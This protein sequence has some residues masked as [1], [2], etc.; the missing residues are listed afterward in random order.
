MTAE[1][2][3]AAD[4]LTKGWFVAAED[5]WNA[6][7]ILSLASVAKGVTAADK[8]AWQKRAVERLRLAKQPAKRLAEDKD[9]DALRGREDFKRLLAP[10]TQ[11]QQVPKEAKRP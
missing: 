6:A 4:E 11:L 3:K 5:Y 2:V 10:S 9:L 1:A 8:E 7:C